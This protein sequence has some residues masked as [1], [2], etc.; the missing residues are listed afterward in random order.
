MNA[1]LTYHSIDESGSP[2]SLAPEIFRA[3]HR[4]L[5]S[6][7]VRVRPLDDLVESRADSGD[8]VAVTFD[9]GFRNTREPIAALLAD[10]VPVTIFAVTRHV[11]GANTW[12]GRSAPGIPTLPLLDW[13]DLGHLVA[14]GASVAAHTRTHP[15]LTGLVGQ[16]LDDELLGGLEDLRDRLGSTA[17]HL[18]YPYGD[19]DGRVAARTGQ[20]YRWGYTTEFSPLSAAA[21]ALLLPRLDMYYFQ[22]PGT[23]EAWGTARF[24]RHVAWCRTRR[25][26]RKLMPFA[27]SASRSAR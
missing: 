4:W 20:F 25:R 5:I 23:L 15:P 1:I 6:G 22:S 10:G 16:A 3:H 12:G 9:D 8:D 19:V 7:K 2:I 21:P 26:L 14:R 18:A 17:A 13:T 24:R 11:G 27:H